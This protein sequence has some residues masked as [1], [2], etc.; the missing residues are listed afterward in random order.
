MGDKKYFEIIKNI[1]SKGLVSLIKL[2]NKIDF[3]LT[4]YHYNPNP[5]NYEDL[6]PK[7]DIQEKEYSK[8]LTWGIKSKNVKNIAI[9]GPYGSGKSSFLKSYERNNKENK[10]LNISL[11]AFNDNE[12]ELN[13]IEES[14]L[15]QIIYSVKPASLPNSKFKRIR[16]NKYPK[17]LLSSFLLLIWIFSVVYLWKVKV[18]SNSNIFLV[19]NVISPIWLCSIVFMSG[20]VIFLNEIQRNISNVKLKFKFRNGEIELGGEKESIFNKYLDEILYFFEVKKFNI[21]YFEDLDR[22]QNSPEIF[23]NLR[24]LNILL[25]NYEQIKN[26]IVF[27]YAIKDDLLTD[28]NRTKF[29]DLMIPIIPVIN[30][31]NSGEIF[32]KKLK[33][34]KLENFS[35]E[36]AYDLSLYID[37]MRMLNNI[38]NEF[39]IYKDKLINNSNFKINN[40]LG[41]I[42]YKNMY[43]KDFSALH[44][45]SGMVYSFFEK[46]ENIIKNK[47]DDIISKIENYKEKLEKLEKENLSNKK[48]LR[49]VYIGAYLNKIPSA[50]KFNNHT[51]DSL[52]QDED[53]FNSLIKEESITYNYLSG[54]RFISKNESINFSD[55]EKIVGEKYEIRKQNLI[56]NKEE[57]KEKIKLE[58]EKLKYEKDTIST[59]AIKN[60][61]QTITDDEIFSEIKNEKLLK[62]LIREGILEEKE[63]HS[64]ISY[65]YEGSITLQ[66][67]DFLLNIKNMEV[68]PYNYKL[69]KIEKII[70]KLNRDDFEKIQILNFNLLEYLIENI[71]KNNY[72]HYF[73][74]II[75]QLSN[76][77][78]TKIEFVDKFIENTKNKDFFIK[79]L[80]KT[81]KIFWEIVLK[82]SNFTEEKN[83]LFLYYIVTFGEINDI[84]NQ[85]SH[86]LLSNFIVK[87]YK[88]LELFKND[89]EL[90]K[91]KEV[92][93]K[94]ELK[95]SN[96]K[97]IEIKEELFLFIIKNRFFLLNI[98]MF[99][100]V[101]AFINKN[102]NE[103][104]EIFR[105]SNY[106]YLN[107][108][109]EIYTDLFEYINGNLNEYIENIFLMEKN[110]TEESEKI[111]L[112]LLNNETI[113][114]QNKVFIIKKE[115]SK[116]ND[117]TKIE[118]KNLWKELVKNNK[119]FPNWRNLYFYFQIQNEFDE[120][121]ENFIDLNMIELTKNNLSSLKVKFKYSYIN[122]IEKNKNE[123]IRRKNEFELS[124]EDYIELINLDIFSDEEKFELIRDINYFFDNDKVE[125]YRNVY[126]FLNNSDNK[127]NINKNLFGIIFKALD[128]IE[129]K[130]RL[131]INQIY[132]LDN[133]EI[134][135]NLLKLS[136]PY[137]NLC[138]NGNPK[139]EKTDINLELI[140]L[141]QKKDFISSFKSGDNYIRVYTK[142]S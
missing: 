30:S 141:L 95:F 17:I 47:K 110:N 15:Q 27:I 102:D 79:N 136:E 24:E 139:F 10:Y 19:D 78:G 62:Y 37:D 94:L 16:N 126:E 96:F 39:I 38:Y 11:A 116:I 71:S 23:T 58:I 64:Y 81:C 90:K 108:K 117:I 119:L 35:E 40:L 118:D 34:L 69:I 42:V 103:E 124:E 67:R 48:E 70:E 142:S 29:F 51:I 33:K 82:K 26:K 88:V 9:S 22:F 101:I 53:K 111:I 43:P 135:E 59:L 83:N 112:K 55:I 6:C 66:D 106:T 133:E 130:I 46:K 50:Y 14:I 12:V 32:V 121:L 72:K 129:K 74:L 132:N 44:F 68:L 4:K 97:E 140:E 3:I 54:S 57:K 104:L 75:K 65:F 109:E 123:F 28:E 137:S 84:L 73:N 89:I 7:D 56:E 31:S 128:S 93:E 49:A 92:I 18:F 13:L 77:E 5:N 86:N 80:L 134:R 8:L 122:Y 41:I 114:Y 87:N 45:N 61:L 91:I 125:V 1:I 131:L 25:N 85:N 100:S 107:N 52:I 113:V 20:I 127:F 2:L 21:V 98:D 120:E 99:Y 105:K 63:Y 138:G 36:I 76:L 60:F 115:D